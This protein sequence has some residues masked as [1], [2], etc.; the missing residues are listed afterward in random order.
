[1]VT[2]AAAVGDQG[3]AENIGLSLVVNDSSE[4]Q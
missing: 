2:E 4:R 1:M 3:H